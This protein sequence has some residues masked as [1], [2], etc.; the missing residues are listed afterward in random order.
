M[1]IK[2]PQSRQPIPPNAK[3]VFKGEVFDVY[4]WKQKLFDGT[5]ATFEK[6]KRADGVNVIPVTAEGK[7]ILGRQ[8]QPGEKPFIGVLGGAMDEGETPLETAK[9]ELLEES[10]YKATKWTLWDAVQ[11]YSKSEWAIYTF[12]ARGCQK[13]Q[14]QTLEPGERIKLL[15]VSFDEYLDII[16]QENYRD[17]ELAL[18]IF[19]LQRDPKQLEETRRLFT[20]S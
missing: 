2:R 17:S 14:A 13:V 3:K 7:I 11:L 4:Q 1:K 5:Y 15:Y 18:K 12:I 8:A 20:G 16:A 10:G 6:I 9:R 19:R